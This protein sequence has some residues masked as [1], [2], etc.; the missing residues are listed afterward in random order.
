VAVCLE[1]ERSAL[2]WAAAGNEENCL[3]TQAS[4]EGSGGG[5]G[6]ISKE[7]TMEM[8]VWD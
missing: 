2:M 7:D 5:E 4:R 1:C 8:R 6:F 3:I